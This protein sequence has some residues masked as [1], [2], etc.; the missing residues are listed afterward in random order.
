MGVSTKETFL[1]FA[2]ADSTFR[3]PH[4]TLQHTVEPP[5]VQFLSSSNETVM[6]QVGLSSAFMNS[7]KNTSRVHPPSI[8]RPTE[9][10]HKAAH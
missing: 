10:M 7:S 8:V 2:A 6:N 4:R 5:S 3:P 9:T 1:Q